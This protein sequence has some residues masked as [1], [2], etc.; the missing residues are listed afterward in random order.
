MSYYF[1]LAIHGHYAVCDAGGPPLQDLG[2]TAGS[3]LAA[4]G[5]VRKK[6]NSLLEPL[7]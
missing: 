4:C 5:P 7:D 2:D 1:K 6:L 3:L